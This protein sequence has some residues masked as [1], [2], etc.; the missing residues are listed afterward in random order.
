MFVEKMIIETD[1]LGRLKKVPLLP[2]NKRLETIF[3]VVGD[4]VCDAPV[5]RQPSSDLK[6]SVKILGNILNST[7]EESWN[8]PR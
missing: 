2:P 3:F 4:S 1:A 8:L 6:G 5:K 7:P